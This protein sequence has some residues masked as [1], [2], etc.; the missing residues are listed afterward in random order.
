M[1]F[2]GKVCPFCKNEFKETDNIVICSNCET[3]HHK[4]CWIE[5]KGCTT[6]ECTGTI[7]EFNNKTQN[8]NKEQVQNNDDS[9]VYCTYCGKRNNNSDR[10]CPC[11]GNIM[12]GN[13]N[14]GM[15]FRSNPYTQKYQGNYQYNYS[16]QTANYPEL[17]LIIQSNGPYYAEKFSKL[18]SGSS[19]VTWN[20]C[21][22][23]FSFYWAFYRKMYGIGWAMIGIYFICLLFGTLGGLLSITMAMMAGFFGDTLYMNHIDNLIKKTQ[24][25]EN[26]HRQVYLRYKGGVS[27]SDIF[28]AFVAVSFVIYLAREILAA[29]GIQ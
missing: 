13:L 10:F 16:Y 21:S 18:K 20:W 23:L 11:C 26:G 22:F 19:S 27:V 28:G 3:P 4:E 29:C 17:M 2:I 24:G 15:Y 1:N 12:R 14:N 25:M 6:P 8:E 9:V 7:K 5:N